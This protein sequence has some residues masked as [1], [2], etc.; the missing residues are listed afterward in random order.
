MNWNGTQKI[1]LK[2]GKKRTFLENGDE[3]VIEESCQCVVEGG[4][5]VRIGFGECAEVT[6]PTSY[7]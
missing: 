1:T 3:I 5:Y 2:D 7:L 4:R 6:L